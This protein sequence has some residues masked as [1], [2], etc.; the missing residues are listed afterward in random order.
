MRSLWWSA[1]DSAL[2]TAGVDGAV[3]QWRPLDG[4]RERDFV[5]KGWAYSCAVGRCSWLRVSEGMPTAV[6][7]AIR[8]G[9]RACQV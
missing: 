1:D 9:V 8:R 5:Q 6:S 4:R 7:P 3:Y 2:L